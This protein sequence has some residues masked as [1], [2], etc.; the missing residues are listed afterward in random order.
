MKRRKQRLG[1]ARP[2]SCKVKAGSTVSRWSGELTDAQCA[3]FPAGKRIGTGSFASAYEYQG[4]RTRVVKFTGDGKDAKASRKLLGKRLRG[5]VHVYDVAQLRGTDAQ[6]PVEGP[7]GLRPGSGPIYA[8]VTERVTP[9][10][11]DDW[12]AASGSLYREI[13][14]AQDEIWKAIQ[15][16]G[17]YF[18]LPVSVVVDATDRCLAQGGE[19]CRE[20]VLEL[21]R[22]IDELGQSG[23]FTADL[24][25]NNW[26]MRGDQPVILDF[27]MSQGADALPIDLAGRRRPRRR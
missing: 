14:I 23:V 20:R 2:S 6:M 13:E 3:R 19:D 26:G 22:V 18:S 11:P 16:E 5:A 21:S 24:H 1:A 4:D 15:T 7:D 17:E 10:L 25:P 27:G 8:I 12:L 9:R